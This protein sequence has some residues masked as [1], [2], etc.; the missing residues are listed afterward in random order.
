MREIHARCQFFVAVIRTS[1]YRSVESIE[2]YLGQVVRIHDECGGSSMRSGTFLNGRGKIV[3]NL[4]M[5]VLSVG[6]VAGVQSHRNSTS[7]HSGSILVSV[8]MAGEAS[9]SPAPSPSASPTPEPSPSPTP[10]PIGCSPGYYKN[11]LS[12]WVGTCCGRRPTRTPDA[13]ITFPESG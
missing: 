13:R 12:A 3:F 1:R 7:D 6:L 2:D 8:A 11:H 9:P 5:I 10:A 4:S